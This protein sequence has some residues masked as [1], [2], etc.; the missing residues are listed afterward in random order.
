MDAQKLQQLM[1]RM[2]GELGAA[3]GA[4]LV[5]IGDELG[6]YKTLAQAGPSTSVELAAR[7]GCAERYVREWLAAQA[8]AGYVEY[9]ATAESFSMTPEQAAVFADENG[10]AFMMGAFDLVSASIRD[11]P[12]IKA[13]FRSGQGVGWHEHDPAL[14]HG[15]ARFFRSSYATHLLSEWI[16][17]LD[18]VEARLRDGARVADVGCGHGVTTVLMARAFPRSSFVGFDYHQ[19]SIEQARKL[20]GEAGVAN[21]AFETA[22]AKDYPGAEYDL[23]AFCDRRIAIGEGRE[24]VLDNFLERALHA[25]RWWKRSSL[26]SSGIPIAREP[27]KFVLLHQQHDIAVLRL[28]YAGRGCPPD[29]AS[30]CAAAW[31]RRRD[32]PGSSAPP[33]RRST[34]FSKCVRSREGVDYCPTGM[35]MNIGKRSD[36]DFSGA[37][38]LRTRCEAGSRAIHGRGALRWSSR[39]KC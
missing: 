5:L 37:A 26:T 28:E 35:R 18:G 17:A 9:D 24:P 19:P 29:A 15:V 31:F 7:T 6:L 39:R 8:A 36:S 10:P 22:T 12:L 38:R 30:R 32:S 14:F 34:P 3:S 21:V 4:A 33:R 23:V 25:G 20:A 16:P 11:V 2:V 13:A 1:G 27:R